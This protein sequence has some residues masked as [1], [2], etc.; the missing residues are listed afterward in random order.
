MW[1]YV[2]F[3]CCS[4]ILVV[5]FPHSMDEAGIC[6]LLKSWCL[7]VVRC[8]NYM[9]HC[10]NIY[11]RVYVSIVQ[12]Y[13]AVILT[14][15]VS[16]FHQMAIYRFF[17][18]SWASLQRWGWT[19]L[20]QTLWTAAIFSSGIGLISRSLIDQFVEVDTWA[21]TSFSVFNNPRWQCF[22]AVL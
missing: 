5:A 17:T 6:L 3:L 16:N 9:M 8:V 7:N 18:W 2:V 4:S 20:T 11:I 22:L 10:Y 21:G 13:W 15:I 12:W 19:R 14:L 1:A